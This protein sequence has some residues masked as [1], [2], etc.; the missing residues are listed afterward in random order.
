M[1][2][3]LK[4]LAVGTLTFI[5][6]RLGASLILFGYIYIAHTTWF[7]T[8][9]KEVMSPS[10][11]VRLAVLMMLLGAG[12]I[13][14]KSAFTTLS[15]T[16]DA[17][18]LPV[19]DGLSLKWLNRGD[20][21]IPV[22]RNKSKAIMDAAKASLLVAVLIAL[23]LI[24][25]KPL[26]LILAV[27]MAIVVGLAVMA[28][29][30]NTQRTSWLGAFFQQPDN[31]CETLLIMG[32]IIAFLVITRQDGLL[33]GTVL[34]LMIAR[35]TSAFRML[36]TNLQLLVRYHRADR[37]LWQRRTEREMANAALKAEREVRRQEQSELRQQRLERLRAEKRALR[38]EQ[39][40]ARA[41]ALR[42][43]EP[44]AAA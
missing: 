14:F 21:T 40:R 38:A 16:L 43:K 28:G 12:V 2:A 1:L 8:Y 25:A 30:R 15:R 27:V 9:A 13:A 23:C 5:V 19:I 20:L 33:S 42:H 18:A 7:L 32:L 26:S 44:P 10:A 35:F 24:V 34:I 4:A 39:A 36:A 29:R 31:Y 6:R 41:D 22:V 3:V 11:D 37:T 17:L